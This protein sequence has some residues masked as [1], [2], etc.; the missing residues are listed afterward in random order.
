MLTN[1]LSAIVKA[2]RIG[3]PVKRYQKMRRIAVRYGVSHSQI[4]HI[5]GLYGD[6]IEAQSN[7]KK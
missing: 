6:A 3:D 2:H 4:L 5:Y 7:E 1:I